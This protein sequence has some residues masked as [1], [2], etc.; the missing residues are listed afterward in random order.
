MK[1]SISALLM[2]TTIFSTSYATNKIPKTTDFEFNSR[3]IIN[4]YASFYKFELPEHVYK[5]GDNRFLRDVYIF[6]N[7]A[8]VPFRLENIATEKTIEESSYNIPFFKTYEEIKN[9]EN[10]RLNINS[11]S[12]S[13]IKLDINNSENLTLQES[14]YIDLDKVKNYRGK[15]NQLTF[16]W[17]FSTQ[18]N[19]IF[20]VSID[21]SND[22]L[23]WNRNSNK[24]MIDFNL[25]QNKV[26][27]N[28]IQLSPLNNNRFMR[29]KIE[30]KHQKP[31][32]TSIVGKFSTEINIKPKRW[33]N[34]VLT[35][36]PENDSE[37]T[38][39]S[40]GN[41]IINGIKITPKQANSLFTANIYSR[42]SEK[43]GWRL[44]GK[45]EI[46]TINNDG[47]KLTNNKI[48][49]YANHD[50]F[51]MI[52]FDPPFTANVSADAESYLPKVEFNWIPHEITFLASGK[53]PFTLAYGNNDKE[54]V[55]QKNGLSS[56]IDF[57]DKKLKISSS[58]KIA[59]PQK[60]IV[61][62]TDEE[63][64]FWEQYKTHILWLIIVSFVLFMLY[65]AT[66]LYKEINSENEG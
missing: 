58:I 66:R 32:I 20:S 46:Y 57:N 34:A 31:N 17:E 59:A 33:H 6:N 35:K 64:S 54:L 21:H 3:I 19:Y 15:L 30:S 53:G 37:Y 45:D 1:A 29:I 4:D 40:D 36:N 65:M 42:S 24:Q 47:N 41:F 52:K 12:E 44:R 22:L 48:S 2:F 28:S 11:N 16:D 7:Q 38:F 10:L 50:K 25:D 5:N 51:W 61:V 9:S 27:E 63:K 56:K 26:K 39:E 8:P 43:M 23:N 13:N 60:N 49:F 62:K 18:G 14:L 55:S